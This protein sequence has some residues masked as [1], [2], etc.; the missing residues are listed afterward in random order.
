MNTVRLSTLS[1]T[2]AIAVMTLGYANPSFADKPSNGDHEHGGGGGGADGAMF[3]VTILDDDLAGGSTVA[4]DEMGKTIDPWLQGFGGKNSIGL[5]DASGLDVGTL[6]GVGSFTGL[7]LGPNEFCFPGD[8]VDPH[9]SLFPLHQAFIKPGKKGRAEAS[10]WFHGT[11]KDGMVRV[12]YLL[13]LIGAFESPEVWPSAQKLTMTD[14]ELKVENEG[15][16]IKSISCIGELPEE[17]EVSVT[18]TV[19]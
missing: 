9:A 18:I 10:F 2:I 6:T 5:N 8:I 11:T 14:W 7:G 19:F 3:R 17:D 13:K 4:V 1:L 15:K 16:A 12:L